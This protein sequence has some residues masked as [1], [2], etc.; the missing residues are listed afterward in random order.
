VNFGSYSQPKVNIEN[1]ESAP[2]TSTHIWVLCRTLKRVI[3]DGFYVGENNTE[4]P[5]TNGVR[6]DM[7]QAL[8]DLKI[9]N[10]RWLEDYGV[11]IAGRGIVNSNRWQATVGSELI[12][13]RILVIIIC[14]YPNDELIV[15]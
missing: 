4:I 13:M 5:N 3:Y 9:P 11:R 15:A 1:D 8:I 7:V 14:L 10:F 12:T 6:I 2:I